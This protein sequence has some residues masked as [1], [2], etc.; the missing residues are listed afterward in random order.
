M[1]GRIRRTLLLSIVLPLVAIQLL[2]HWGVS[3]VTALAIATIFPLIE[4]ALEF[5][6]MKRIGVIAMVA[7]AGIVTG[8]G[9]AFITGNGIFAVLKDSAFTFVFGVIFLGSLL[10]KRPLIYTLNLDLAVTDAA[11]RAEGIALWEKPA[12]RRSFRLMTI[13]WGIGLML[14]AIVRVI[15]TLSVPLATAAALSPVISLAA[16]GALIVWTMLYARARRAAAPA[17]AA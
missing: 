17:P 9:V 7:L 16:V 5:A 13:V 1:S 3:P 4:M 15:V 12:A 14:D 2:L 6:E 10:T 11:A 8:F